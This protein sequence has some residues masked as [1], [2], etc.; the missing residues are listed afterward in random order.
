MNGKLIGIKHI[1]GTS[2]KDG[3]PFSFSVACITTDMNEK[4]VNNGS[5]GLD[6]HTPTIPERCAGYLNE[7]AIGKDIEV[8]FYYANGR[9]NIAYCNLL[10]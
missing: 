10:K 5:K 8:E 2:K 4:D 9:E 7:S 6:V 1:S 3:K